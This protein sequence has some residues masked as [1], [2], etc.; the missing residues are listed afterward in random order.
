MSQSGSAAAGSIEAGRFNDPQEEN[1]LLSKLD[2]KN[3][4]PSAR[5]LSDIACVTRRRRCGQMRDRRPNKIRDVF[6]EHIEDLF[7]LRTMQMLTVYSP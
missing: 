2:E 6:A 7:G 4:L 1:C 3:I 5:S